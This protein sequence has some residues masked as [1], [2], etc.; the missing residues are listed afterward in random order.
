MKTYLWILYSIAT[1]SVP[2]DATKFTGLLK[3]SLQVGIPDNVFSQHYT[4]HAKE[5]IPLK[6]EKKLNVFITLD[7]SLIWHPV[8][9]PR[10]ATA[11]ITCRPSFNRGKNLACHSHPR[12][13]STVSQPAFIASSKAEAGDYTLWRVFV[14]C[15]LLMAGLQPHLAW[16]RLIGY[17]LGGAAHLWCMSNHGTQDKP[18][19]NTHTWGGA[20][21]MTRVPSA[22]R[23]PPACK[24]PNKHPVQHLPVS[25]VGGPQR[26]AT[27]VAC[28]G[29]TL[30]HTPSCWKYSLNWLEEEGIW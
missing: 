6:Y 24:T 9:P 5:P 4:T 22:R 21:V 30:P 28:G 8:S 18:A 14:E 20:T 23:I 19:I 15:V 27:S 2:L 13:S 26:K 12:R 1:K 10:W 17:W 3:S 29:A 16:V 25:C 7:I 11:L